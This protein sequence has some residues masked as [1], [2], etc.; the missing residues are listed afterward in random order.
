MVPRKGVWNGVG[1]I[2]RRID[3]ARGP[4]LGGWVRQRFWEVGL[5]SPRIA[6][7]IRTSKNGCHTLRHSALPD[8]AL[9]LRYPTSVWVT[10][11]A[12]DTVSIDRG[13]RAWPAAEERD[14]AKSVARSVGCGRRSAT[15]NKR[16]DRPVK[17]HRPLGRCFRLR[18]AKRAPAS[19]LSQVSSP[20]HPQSGKLCGHAQHIG[21][22][23]PFPIGA[24]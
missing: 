5:L 10:P 17:T 11:R 21:V 12:H 9:R 22:P 1:I 20:F 23:H 4:T 13:V 6:D 7:R 15:A 14:D 19:A 18:A 2:F 16:A 3:R 8:G 24:P